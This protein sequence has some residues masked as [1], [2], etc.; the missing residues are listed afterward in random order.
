VSG[1]LKGN[2]VDPY[3]LI[4]F[5]QPWSGFPWEIFVKTVKFLYTPVGLMTKSL[6]AFFL[7]LL[8]IFIFSG[9]KKTVRFRDFILPFI[10]LSFLGIALHIISIILFHISLSFPYSVVLCMVLY[11]LIFNC[12]ILIS[13]FEVNLYRSILAIIASFLSVFFISGF[14]GVAPYLAW[15]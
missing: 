8:L 5:V 15:I 11:L 1:Y 7:F 2:R 12:I 10:G 13:E 9:V 3:V 4:N 6:L 14:S